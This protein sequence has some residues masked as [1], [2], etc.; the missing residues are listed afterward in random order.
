MKHI[1]PR[2]LKHRAP[3]LMRRPLTYEQARSRG[4]DPEMLERTGR[5][6]ITVPSKICSACHA[7]SRTASRPAI[8]RAVAA[9]LL[10]ESE[11]QVLLKAHERTVTE[12]RLAGLRSYQKVRQQVSWL[13]VIDALSRDPSHAPA[14]A[15][16]RLQQKRGVSRVLRNLSGKRGYPSVAEVKSPL[17]SLTPE[18]ALIECRAYGFNPAG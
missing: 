5:W 1:C 13:P 3:Y 18:Q 7:A 16:A 4:Y 2:C 6:P 17:Y 14:L 8:E 9:G 10:R 15:W 12:R 11:A